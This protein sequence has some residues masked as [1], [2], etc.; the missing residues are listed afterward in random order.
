VGTNTEFLIELYRRML[1]ARRVEERLAALFA[2]GEI[3]GFI[4]LGIGQEAVAIGV[5]AALERTDT[6][7]SNH[8]GHGHALGKGTAIGP[9]FAEIMGKATGICGGRGGSMHVADMAVGM[10]GANGIVA[11]GA[12]LALDSAMAFKV[13]KTRQVATVFFGEGAGGEGIV[14]ESMNLAALW[15]LPLL[16]VCE[17]NGWAEFSPSGRQ[18]A[19]DLQALAG[20]YGIPFQSVDGNDVVAVNAAAV[21]IIGSMRVQSG[22]HILERRTR[23]VRGHYEGDAQKYRIGEAAAAA[24]DDPLVRCEQKLTQQAVP[25]E[26]LRQIEN[27]VGA[28]IESAVAAA[29]AA[30]QPTF[31]TALADVYTLAGS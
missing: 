2:A 26:R 7:A 24:G 16:L 5:T 31:G 6:L 15:R 9:F 12:S 27:A 19:V 1:M 22:P 10:L 18:I 17:H 11:A 21:E 14:H 4:N 28:Q 20:A 13:R 29:R 23:R 25:P 8:R 3:P 30:P